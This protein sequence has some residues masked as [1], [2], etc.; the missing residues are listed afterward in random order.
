MKIPILKI[1]ITAKEDGADCLKVDV[2]GSPNQVLVFI[3]RARFE[4][5]KI[6]SS[7]IETLKKDVAE[8]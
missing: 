4:L 7:V 2:S 3:A 8:R 5:S 1:E 6:E